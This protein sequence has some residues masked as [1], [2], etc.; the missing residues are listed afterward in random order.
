MR[1]IGGVVTMRVDPKEPLAIRSVSRDGEVHARGLNSVRIIE[2]DQVRGTSRKIG[3]NLPASV[4]ASTISYYNK[5]IGVLRNELIQERWKTR[6]LV[7][8]GNDDQDATHPTIA[9]TSA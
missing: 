9:S 5:R 8:A 1:I 2:K 7:Q 4:A 3:N 6:F